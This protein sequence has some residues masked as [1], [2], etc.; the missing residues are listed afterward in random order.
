MLRS[1]TVAVLIT[2]GGVLIASRTPA[3][4]AAGLSPRAAN[5]VAVTVT[6][7]LAHGPGCL[8]FA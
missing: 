1:C 7:A 2:L 5:T 6:L 3:P 8:V 4:N